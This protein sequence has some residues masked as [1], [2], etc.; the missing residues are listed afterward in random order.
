MQEIIFILN[1][2]R[3]VI[4]K[5]IRGGS[6]LIYFY[7]QVIPKG[8]RGGSGLIYFYRQVIPE[9]K[10]PGSQPGFSMIILDSPLLPVSFQSNPVTQQ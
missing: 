2:Y 8:I 9:W 7:R 6:G 3:Q 4:P 1:F 10:K 5:G